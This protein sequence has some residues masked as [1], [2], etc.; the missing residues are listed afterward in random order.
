MP[1]Q[2]HEKIQETYYVVRNKEYLLCM[3]ENNTPHT[4]QISYRPIKMKMRL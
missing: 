4:Q 1:L 3:W 2:L